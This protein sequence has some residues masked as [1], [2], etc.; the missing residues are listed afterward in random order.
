M[1]LLSPEVKEE[2]QNVQ[3]NI[4]FAVC[5]YYVVIS[6]IVIGHI[7]VKIINW[8]RFDRT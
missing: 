2:V 4:D 7:L 1:L 5:D 3:S 8:P 6:Y